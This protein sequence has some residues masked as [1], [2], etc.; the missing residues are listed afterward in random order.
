[1]KILKMIKKVLYKYTI[2]LILNLAFFLVIWYFLDKYFKT[3]WIIFISA[4]ILSI[5][6]LVI[7]TQNL[8]RKN[9]SKLE[10]IKEVIKNNNKK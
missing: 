7:M 10:N 4:L 6:S 9:L 8:V 3:N 2:I 5:V 1:M